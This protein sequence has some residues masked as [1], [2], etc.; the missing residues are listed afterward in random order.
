MSYPSVKII[1]GD[2]L[3]ELKKLE[4]GF[5]HC[6]VTSPPYW[7]LR[8]YGIA[9]QIGLEDSPQLYIEKLSEVF[10]EVHRVLRPDGTLWLNIGDTYSTTEITPPGTSKSNRGATQAAGIKKNCGGVKPKNLLGIPWRLAFSLQNFGWFLRQDIIWSKPNPMPE[11]VVDRCTKAHEYVFLFSKSEKYFFNQEAI[12][13]P[14]ETEPHSFGYNVKNM[15]ERKKALLATQKTGNQWNE[16]AQDKIIG[17]DGRRNKRSVW[18]VPVNSYKDAHFATFPEDLIKPMI[19]A[20]CPIGGHVLDPFG[21]SGTVG[22]VAV[23]FARNATLI[24]LNPKFVRMESGRTFY[25]T[26]GLPLI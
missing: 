14:A 4:S 26:A 10:K 24:E 6:V 25:T 15:E 3:T 20:G 23:E 17:E 19:L 7:C 12:L 5:F 18:H 22:K 2:S 16:D 21:G 1:L 9:G 13:E 11:S 8:D